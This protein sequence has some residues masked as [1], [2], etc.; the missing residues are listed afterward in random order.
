MYQVSGSYY[1]P[2]EVL[3]QYGDLLPSEELVSID[4]AYDRTELSVN[5]TVEVRV[6]IS[7][8][9]P[10]GQAES[11]LIDLGIPPGF[12]VQAED[13]AALVARFNDVPQDYAFPT[14]ERF[15][16]TGR[17]ILV[18]VSNLSADN[19]LSFSYRLQAKYPLIAQTPAS[20][21]YDYYNPEVSGEMA[22][23]T[24]VVVP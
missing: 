18:Y 11:A 19:P 5:D 22:P 20:S 9:Q 1:L 16:L 17:Q 13:L 7:L 3:A 4:V 23:Q 10:S 15:E 12:S 2:W 21:A 8:N 6:N 24:L 14:I